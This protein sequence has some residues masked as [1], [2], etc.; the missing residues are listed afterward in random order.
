MLITSDMI[1]QAE[2]FDEHLK[3]I[4]IHQMP[5]TV[6]EKMAR[7]E[8]LARYTGLNGQALEGHLKELRK[9]A[10]EEVKANR[11]WLER[12]GLGE[13]LRGRE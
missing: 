9:G 12:S 4:A 2:N 7:W 6:E 11:A 1:E 13:G 10:E 8:K 5:E 3:M